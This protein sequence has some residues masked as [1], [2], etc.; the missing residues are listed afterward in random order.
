[1]PV[2][3]RKETFWMQLVAYHEISGLPKV[4]RPLLTLQFRLHQNRGKSSLFLLQLTRGYN[5]P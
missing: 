5:F 2:A 4:G 3:F 1:M